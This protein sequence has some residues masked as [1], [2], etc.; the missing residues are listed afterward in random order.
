MLNHEIKPKLSQLENAEE[1]V[2]LSLHQQQVLAETD[3][4]I[5]AAFDQMQESIYQN[6][7]SIFG[8]INHH[9]QWMQ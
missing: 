5:L 3:M 2:V 6:G 9:Q 8:F 1:S 7:P 4:S